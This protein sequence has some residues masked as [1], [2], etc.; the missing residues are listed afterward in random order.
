MVVSLKDTGNKSSS[1]LVFWIT[2]SNMTPINDMNMIID[3]VNNLF[4]DNYNNYDKMRDHF[5]ASNTYCPRTLSLFSS[6]CD[7]DYAT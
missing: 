6:D 4:K 1:T 2:A 7:E 3:L 5:L